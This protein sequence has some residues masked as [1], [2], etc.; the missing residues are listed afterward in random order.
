MLQIDQ[1]IFI[2]T[3]YFLPFEKIEKFCDVNVDKTTPK[4]GIS[5]VFPNTR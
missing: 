2:D 3:N 1:Q 4:S 5:I